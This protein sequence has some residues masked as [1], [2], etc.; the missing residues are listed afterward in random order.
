MFVNLRIQS[1]YRKIRARNNSVFGHFSRSD[2]DDDDDDDDDELF[3]VWLTDESRLALFPF[4][5]IVR[6]P[7][8]RESPTRHEQDLNL[9]RT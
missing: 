6:D 1:E 7:H 2:D 4:G 9:R 5:T 3:V 8:H